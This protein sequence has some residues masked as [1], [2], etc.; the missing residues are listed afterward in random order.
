MD[1]HQWDCSQLF[2][3]RL[4]SSWGLAAAFFCL[5]P[6]T[7]KNLHIIV[8]P[9]TWA[10][11]TITH[12]LPDMSPSVGSTAA[13]LMWWWERRCFTW[14]PYLFTGLHDKNNLVSAFCRW[15]LCTATVLHIYK[16]IM[17]VWN[18]YEFGEEWEYNVFWSH[19]PSFLKKR[20]DPS[21]SN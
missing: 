2:Q 7:S 21:S 10:T 11:V 3:Q 14:T 8:D 4:R 12:L 6:A 18:W 19:P 9:Q 16:R 15:L 1:C 20:V 17:M 13:P 5:S